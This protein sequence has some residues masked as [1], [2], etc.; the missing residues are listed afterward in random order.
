MAKTKLI[1]TNFTGGE[2]SPL[3]LGRV[4]T[5]KHQNGAELLRNMVVRQQG[6]A[7][8]R[9]G[10]IFTGV[11]KDQTKFTLLYEFE[12]S[13]TQNY[14]L[15]IGH[16][17]FRIWYDG[18]FVETA[19]ASGVPLNIDTLYT[20]AQLKELTFAQSADVLY[21]FHGSHNP[22]KIRRLGANSWD[23]VDCD[24]QDGPYMTNPSSVSLQITEYTS[25]G[26]A[27]SNLPVFS[28]GNAASFGITAINFVAGHWEFTTSANHGWATN[29]VVSISGVTYKVP[30]PRQSGVFIHTSIAGTYTITVS[31]VNKFWISG[32]TWTSYNPVPGV[33]PT[34]QFGSGLVQSPLP[35]QHFDYKRDNTWYLAKMLTVTDSTHADVQVYENVKT[36]ITRAAKISVDTT[37]GTCTSTLAGVFTLNDIGKYIKTTAGN[38]FQITGYNSDSQVTV[39]AII[40]VLSY[41]PATTYITV[42]DIVR[43]GSV[44]ALAASFVG[45]DVGRLIRFNFGGKRP[46]GAIMT[47][48]STTQVIVNFQ[49]DVPLD[50]QNVA[51]LY[52]NGVTQLWQLGSWSDTTGYPKSG[53]FHEQRLWLGGTLTEPLNIWGSQPNDYENMAPT[54]YDSVVLDTNALNY[55]LVSDKANPIIWMVSASTL[56]VGTLGSEWQ[57]KA[58]ASQNQPITPANINARPQ[59]NNGSKPKCRPMKVGN[60]VTFVQKA[61]AKLL[62]TH[63][64]FNADSFLSTNLCI[65]SE[66]ILREDGGA[67]QLAY[68]RE[69]NNVVWLLTD[70]G[71]LATLTYERDQQVSAWSKQI[72]A[73]SN[74]FVESI[75]VTGSNQGKDDVVYAVVRRTI[76]GVTKRY[77]ERFSPDYF[78]QSTTDTSNFF[79]V[80]CGLTYSGAPTSTVNGL[81]HL[82]GETVDIVADG[83]YRGTAV[84][85]AGSIAVIPGGPA[86]KIHVGYK[87]TALIK[88]LRQDGG[89]KDGGTPQG[90]VSR[91]GRTAIRLFASRDFKYG[92]YLERLDQ[93]KVVDGNGIPTTKLLTGDAIVSMPMSYGFSNSFYIVQDIPQPL[94]VLAIMPD[95]EVTT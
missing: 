87:Y 67:V 81:A 31:A 51:R 29:Q 75:A 70:A 93:Y 28:L 94:V 90:K 27:L 18:G 58:A 35:A 89:S 41:N 12:Y 92:Q 55:T 56:I 79:L 64:D 50:P 73:G 44:T 57:V 39:G 49:A 8:I 65:V 1:Q 88:T 2:L 10:T 4:D 25:T 83:V 68:Q 23:I 45:T 63:Y 17:Y 5:V 42:S 40:S 53:C 13:D 54:E 26:K 78:A 36:G 21:V 76:G 60:V 15:E 61:G 86:S 16:L 11:V 22:R 3:M 82:E 9:G 6:G 77:I 38:W 46:W 59:S 34:W 14:I 43:Q 84:V 95:T 37:Q 48:L 91:I 71:K 30:Y 20:E 62:E 7:W 74:V 72:I 80:D 19:P 52:D 47:F 33:V 66:H 85:N 69:P 24:F 32:Q